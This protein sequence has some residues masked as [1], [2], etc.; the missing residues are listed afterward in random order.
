MTIVA[1]IKLLLLASIVGNVLALAFQA[2]AIDTR[3]RLLPGAAASAPNA[4]QSRR[5]WLLRHE[6]PGR[7]L[8]RCTYRDP[9]RFRVCG[10]HL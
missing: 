4:D 10:P 1:A 7:G 9:A 2:R 8:V 3:A 5:Q 6:T